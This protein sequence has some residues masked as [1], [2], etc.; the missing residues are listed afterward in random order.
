MAKLHPGLQNKEFWYQDILLVC[1]QLPDFERE[2]VDLTSQFSR[3]IKLKTPFVSSPMD[4]VTEAEMA[5]LMALMGG[6]GVIHYNYATIDEQM[7]EVEKVKRF[8]A[9][10]VRKPIVLSPENTVADIYQI[11]Q[12]YG[13]YSVPITQDGTSKSKL[14]G[15]VTH[16]DVRYLETKKEMTMPLAKIMTPKEKLITG[17]KKDTLDKN[18]IRAVNKIIRKYNLDTLPIIDE[19]SRLV[20]IVTDSDLRKNEMYPLA[21][22]DKNKQLKVLIAV[23]SRLILAQE[24][25]KKAIGA[26]VDGIVID[27]SVVFREQ[28]EIA[29]YV[30]ENFPSLEVILGNVDSGKMVTEI[31]KN[32]GKWVDGLRVGIGP[33]AACITQ[34][35]LGIGRAQASAVWDCGQAT[36]KMAKKL[37]FQVPIIADG[38]IR[39]P[40][41]ITKALALGAQT[42][43]MGS[44][45]AGLEESP[46]EVV[47]DEEL[48]YLIKNYRGMGSLEAMEKRSSVRYGIEKVKIKV[49]EGKVTKVGYKGSGYTFLPKLVAAVKQGMQKLGAKD[50]PTLQRIAEI[51]PSGLL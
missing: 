48:G 1:N 45:L 44:L 33:G 21:T 11:A 20:A 29:K 5:I 7:A 4:T 36:K 39:R 6:I 40:S 15:I 34:E 8:E 26:G 14:V 27:A 28:L 38:S 24:R 12:K 25:L 17:K 3:N 37:G 49:P 51:R 18:D 46:G 47:F 13:F 43:M 50:I 35:Y 41:D 9:A 31:I 32:V 22:K 10:F 23:E 2:E 19:N 42:V 16:R 30:K